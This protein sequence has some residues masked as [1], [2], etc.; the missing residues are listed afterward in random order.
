MSM[1]VQVFL[2]TIPFVLILEHSDILLDKELLPLGGENFK[3]LTQ[4]GGLES[5]KPF[6]HV[7][8]GIN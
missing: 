2:I 8:F 1:L 7:W 4:E 3:Q 5:E 6:C